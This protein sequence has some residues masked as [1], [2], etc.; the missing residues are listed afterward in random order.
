MS[1]DAKKQSPDKQ[2]S[3]PWEYA[4]LILLLL[5][6]VVLWLLP[7]TFFDEGPAI[8]PSKVFFGFEC[9]GCG[10]TRAVMHVH[11]LQLEEAIF[12]NTGVVV[13]FPALVVIWS[14][15]VYKSA[16][17]LYLPGN[18]KRPSAQ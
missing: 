1:P 3:K 13:V 5:T 10:M 2:L 16:R 7:A 12:Y 17:R 9:L 11:H 8:C 15:W 14:V 6:P 18:A 4:W